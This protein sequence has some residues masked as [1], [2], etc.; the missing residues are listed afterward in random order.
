MNDKDKTIICLTTC[1][2]ASVAQSIAEALVAEHL[3]ACVNRVAGVAST[4]IWD[5]KLQND[6]EIL[7]IIKT[8]E[9]RWAELELRL[10]ALHPYEL[11]ELISIPVC[12]GS[13]RY[14]DWVRQ[15]TSPVM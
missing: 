10:K 6:S 5:G 11:P 2:T 1:P 9:A 8:T 15:S 7:L 13:A 4:Y 14:L 12:A 3:A